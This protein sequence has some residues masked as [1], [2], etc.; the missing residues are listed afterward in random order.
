MIDPMR[1]VWY[2]RAM[3]NIPEHI[4]ME[5]RRL[6]AEGMPVEQIAFY[7][8]ISEHVI[9]EEIEKQKSNM[10]DHIPAEH[11]AM[12]QKLGRER[13]PVG[14]IAFLTHMSEITVHEVLAIA[15]IEPTQN[16]TEK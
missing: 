6:I 1:V 5:V 7:T 13:M 4:M 11:I 8:R 9:K 14:R 3:S 2:S 15:G 12:I 16:P 10:T